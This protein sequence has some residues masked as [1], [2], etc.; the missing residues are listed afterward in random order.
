MIALRQA[1]LVGLGRPSRLPRLP[2]TDDID[3]GA[4]EVVLPDW[5]LPGAIVHAAYPSRRGLMPAVRLFLDFLGE[6]F[7]SRS[8]DAWKKGLRRPL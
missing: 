1:A 2:V 8:I 3:Q 6:A 4:L 7:A 5:S